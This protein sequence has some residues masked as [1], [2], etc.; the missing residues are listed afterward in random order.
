MGQSEVIFLL[1]LAVTHGLAFWAGWAVRDRKH[2][3][4]HRHR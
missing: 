2:R 4:L 1:C 3:H